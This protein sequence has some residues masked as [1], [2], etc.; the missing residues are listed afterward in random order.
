MNFSL[1]KLDITFHN[2]SRFS[3]LYDELTKAQWLV[4]VYVL[5]A[6]TLR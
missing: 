5:P 4:G 2:V 1:H 3:I 6:F